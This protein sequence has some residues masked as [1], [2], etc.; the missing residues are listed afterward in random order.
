MHVMATAESMPE[1][2]PTP[3]TLHKQLSDEGRALLASSLAVVHATPSTTSNTTANATANAA[4]EV[5]AAAEHPRRSGPKKK[6]LGREP[7]RR[8]AGR[9]WNFDDQVHNDSERRALRLRAGYVVQATFGKKMSFGVFDN[10]VS[11]DSY[12]YLVRKI[13]LLP[14]VAG[15]GSCVAAPTRPLFQHTT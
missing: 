10:E 15:H 12:E 5:T 11:T 1:K 7:K 4:A 14:L 6:D 3:R 2:L 8:K 13:C 9:A